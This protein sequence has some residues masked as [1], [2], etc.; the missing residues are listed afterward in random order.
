MIN[1]TKKIV[2]GITIETRALDS[3][4]KYVREL[5]KIER[6]FKRAYKVNAEVTYID[7]KL[8]FL[9]CE[10]DKRGFYTKTK[11]Q[12][13]VFVD[14]NMENNI[15]TL[16]HELTHA[17]QN[18]YI[19]DKYTIS[20]KLLKTGKVSYKNAWHEKHARHCAELL[21]NT[22]DFSLSLDNAFDFTLKAC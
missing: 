22:Y 17:Y 2:K 7:V 15:R 18:K 4:N 21:S 16:L 10:N 12:A 6:K 19:N 11:N 9:I 3:S 8:R 1:L 14:G 13:V 20:T 5:K